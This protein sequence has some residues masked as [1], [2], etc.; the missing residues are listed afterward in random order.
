MVRSYQRLAAFAA[1]CAMVT[2]TAFSVQAEEIGPGVTRKMEQQ[3]QEEQVRES[4]IEIERLAAAEAETTDKMIVVVG[5]GIDSANINLAYFKK[6][7][8][9][10]WQEEFYVPGY[11]GYSGM[12]EN[13]REGDRRTPVGIYRFTNAF[14]IKANPGSILDYK[15]LDEY[16]YW[17]DDSNSKYYNQMVST[18][19]VAATWKSAEHLIAVNPSY[20]YSLALDYNKE[21]IPKKGSAIF[22]HG[23]HPTKTWT[24]GCIAIDENRVAELIQQVDQNTVI[25]IVKDANALA[26]CYV[27]TK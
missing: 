16:D 22:L 10:S 25:V 4:G 3:K 20:N 24:E 23:L 19:E 5:T 14:G 7:E 12:A 9:N 26:E 8:N 17:V 13:K 11:C 27:E 21:C 18:K 6:G 1:V 2:I 15:E